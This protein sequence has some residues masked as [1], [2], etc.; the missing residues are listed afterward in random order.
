MS[1]VFTNPAVCNTGPLIGLHRAGLAHL[2]AMLFPKVVIPFE[3]HRELAVGL[4]KGEAWLSDALSGC[5]RMTASTTIDPLLATQLDEGEAS[6]IATAMDLGINT[7]LIDEKRGRRVASLVYGLH[8][9]GTC[10]LLLEAKL[11]N[12]IP[13]VSDALRQMLAGGYF[14][15]RELTQETIRLAGE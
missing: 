12:L 11:R 15:G 13:S 9:K 7:V 10:G 6:V 3:V 1:D 5:E 14:L 4:Q 8:V 2:P